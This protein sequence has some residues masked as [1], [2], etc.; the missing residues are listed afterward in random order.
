MTT[1]IQGLS[2]HYEVLGEGPETVLLLHGWGAPVTA[3]RPVLEL[4]AQRFRV[5]AFDMPGVGGTAEPAEP[6]TLDDYVGFTLDFC[7]EIGL[8]RAVLV[9]HSHG[10][11][12]AARLLSDRAC[13]LQCE[14]AV[15]IDA[16]GVPPRRTL[17]WKLR[18]RAYKLLRALGTA[19][20]TA[21]LFAILLLDR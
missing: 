4:L 16:A 9:C 18:Q 13:P 12:I 3:Y 5:V 8:G 20:L 19:R 10:G 2:V 11:R 1:T 15:F 14:R 6:L 17:G 7:R 21:P